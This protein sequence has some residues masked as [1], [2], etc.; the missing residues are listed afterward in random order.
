MNA[1]RASALGRR[2]PGGRPPAR[3]GHMVRAVLTEPPAER[4]AEARKARLPVEGAPAD[5]GCAEA[6]APL[7]APRGHAPPPRVRG[8]DDAMAR[9]RGF[10][11]VVRLPNILL[12]ATPLRHDHLRGPGA[13]ACP[14]SERIP[15]PAERT[16]PARRQ[17]V[18]D[19]S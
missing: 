18:G 8:T 2:V 11:V 15:G 5:P 7:T 12:E 6:P 13:G 9:Q 3:P 14:V 16:A 19:T 1:G 17:N 4:S 10:A